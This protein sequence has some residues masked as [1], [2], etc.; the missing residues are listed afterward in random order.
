MEEKKDKKE[1]IKTEVTSVAK[2]EE[3]TGTKMEMPTKEEIKQNASTSFIRS[4]YALSNVFKKLSSKA[5]N[6]VLNA[7]IDLPKDNI[8]VK[9]KSN[10]EQLAFAL[11]QR[12]ISDRYILTSYYIEEQALEQKRLDAERLEKQELEEEKL[13]EVNT[14]TEKKEEPKNEGVKKDGQVS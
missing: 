4:S 14:K 12:A 1:E 5:K 6:R 13:E 10:D 3:K 7:I 8:P 9:L 2:E 11:G